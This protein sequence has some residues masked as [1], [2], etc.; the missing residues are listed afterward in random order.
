[1]KFVFSK[2]QSAFTLIELLVVIAIIAILAAILFP[3]FARARENARRTSCLSNLKQIG[4]G[5]QQYQQDYDEK[6]VPYRLDG[7]NPFTANANVGSSAKTVVFENQLLDPYIKSAQIWV[8][9]SKPNGWV[10]VDPIG[11]ESDA[12]H[13]S[14]GGQNSYGVNNY[15]MKSITTTAGTAV[16]IAAFPEVATTIATV[17]AGYYNVLPSS[18]CQLVGDSF[19]PT[20]SYQNYWQNMGNS[21]YFR[22]SGTPTTAE[23]IDLIKGRHLETLNA[24]YLDGHAKS[25]NWT[26]I[27]NDA[28]AVGKKDSQWD[29]FKNGC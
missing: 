8:C 19:N 12:A 2:P 15:A 4:L 9:P 1:M 3:V 29:P 21:Y 17:D 26:K 11:T 10:N 25:I 14:Y 24:L 22:A 16:S 27:V 23:S 7:T 6:V 20:G 28:P 13:R 5:M 18:P